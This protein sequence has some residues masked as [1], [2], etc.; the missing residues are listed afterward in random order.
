MTKELTKDNE[1][2]ED[3]IKT[4]LQLNFDR[5]NNIDN[6]VVD[7]KIFVDEMKKINKQKRK[8]VEEALDAIIRKNLV[9]ILFWEF[10]VHLGIIGGRGS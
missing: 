2:I 5:L 7:N 6:L 8:D 1:I 10:W 3:Q 4:I 9:T